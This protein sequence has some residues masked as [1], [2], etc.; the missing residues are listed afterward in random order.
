[1]PYP[2]SHASPMSWH[3]G[4]ATSDTHSFAPMMTNPDAVSYGPLQSVPDRYDLG[5]A[6]AGMLYP[7]HGTSMTPY[8]IGHASPT[9]RHHDMATSDTHSFAPMMANSDAV[10]YGPLQG[11]PDHYDLRDAR[12]WPGMLYPP[13][14][15]SLMSG[16]I[17][18][19]SPTS[20]HH[21]M[22][23]SEMHSFAPMTA[24]PNVP[25][26]PDNLR[27]TLSYGPSQ[28]VP[29]P[30]DFLHLGVMHQQSELPITRPPSRLRV[31]KWVH[32]N[33]RCGYEGTLEDLNK[34]WND[35]H[36][37]QCPGV[38]IKCKWEKCRY[39]NRRKNKNSIRVMWRSS[40]WRHISEAHL[41]CPR[42]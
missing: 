40:M 14:G 7:P 39:R 6:R 30:H 42:H 41:K 19:T 4:M 5:D 17:S 28:N 16:S 35:T 2:I 32:N 29:Y 3:H 15:T 37:P 21:G 8:P 34:H 33:A 26:T 27:T 36:L 11:V 10:S 18:H 13:H 1:M 38:V 9:S 24:N 22:A 20:R 23:T 31:C 12:F 25:S